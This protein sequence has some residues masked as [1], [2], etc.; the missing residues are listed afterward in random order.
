M[1]GNGTNGNGTN[2]NGRDPGSG[3][4]VDRLRSTLIDLLGVPSPSG[5]TDEVV[6]VLGDRLVAM[7]LTPELTRRGAIAVKPPGAPEG[8]ARAMVAHADTIGLVVREIKPS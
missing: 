8:P 1:N 5:R 6:Q 2:G 3:I 7:G 4:D